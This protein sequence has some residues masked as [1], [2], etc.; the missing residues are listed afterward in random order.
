MGDDGFLVE[1]MDSKNGTFVGGERVT[2]PRKLSDGDR[3]SVGADT[4]LKF[5]LQDKIDE[6][7]QQRLRDAALI[8]SLTQLVRRD[9]FMRR[10]GVEMRHGLRHRL[11]LAVLMID[12]DRFKE[13]NDTFGHIIGDGVL[14]EVAQR[15]ASQLRIDDLAARYG[16][17]EFA[18]L[19]RGA[20]AA[21]GMV[22]AERIRRSMANK[23][24]DPD[25][26]AIK[27]TVSIGVACLVNLPPSSEAPTDLLK[28]ADEALYAAKQQGRN[29]V[30]LAP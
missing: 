12:I 9:Y 23:P 26:R 18:V 13:V 4:V 19:C 3:V 16:G 29:R 10:L 14:T 21:G 8:D 11:P 20:D 7:F 24:I 15:I 1:D 22:V 27:V 2:A 6:E 30:I 25:H 5:C 28:V 17:E